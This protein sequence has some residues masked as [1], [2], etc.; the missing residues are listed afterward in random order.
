MPDVRRAAAVVPAAGRSER[1]GSMKLLA[2]VGGER[3]LDRTLASLIDAGVSP[4]VVVTAPGAAFDDVSRLA[5]ASV[6]RAVNPDPSRGMFSS[7]QH[8]LASVG[9][10]AVLV[11]PADM[12][13]VR[14]ATVEAVAAECVRANRVVIPRYDA[15]K[16]HPVGV[17]A[18]LAG[19]LLA[20]DPSLSLKDALA[21]QG[22]DPLFLDV[23][24]QGVVHDVDRPGDLSGGP[25]D[26]H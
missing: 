16:G 10:R 19:A 23:D 14:P 13:F 21:R 22:E 24:D 11:L 2:D 8:G 7:I 18:R 1:F 17:P 15:R 6:R 25:T 5:N 4:I 3:L 12:P 9:E 26:L 20:A